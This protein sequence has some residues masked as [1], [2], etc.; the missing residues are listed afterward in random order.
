MWSHG[1]PLTARSNQYELVNGA[2]SQS[3][4]SPFD[5]PYG[6][7]SWRVPKIVY[8]TRKMFLLLIADLVLLGIILHILSPLISL[9]HH[10]QELFPAHFEVTGTQV[11][12]SSI[13]LN[14]QIPRILH[15]TAKNETIPDIWVNSQASCLTTYSQYE[16]K[17]CSSAV[18]PR[19]VLILSFSCGRMTE[20]DPSLQLNIRG[21]Y[22][23]GTIIH[24]LSNAP[25][26]S[27]ILLFTTMVGS[28]LIWI[29]YATKRFLS[30]ESKLIISLII[31][32]S[33]VRYRRE[34]PTILWFRLPNI[35]HLK[36][37]SIFSLYPTASPG[38]GLNC[39]HMLLSC[40]R[41]VL[42]SSLWLLQTI[43]SSSLLCLR[44]QFRLLPLL[45][46][47]HK[48]PIYRQ[49]PGTAGMLTP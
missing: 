29:P 3:S 12:P 17:V 9:L 15:Q 44:R 11:S 2:E 47:A 35:P 1:H 23:Y 43:C 31:A 33:K 26:L 46:S 10:N 41:R 45:G 27:D 20:P 42:Y 39:N 34:S 25:M 36:E 4:V 32:S 14:H 30:T 5:Y 40:H 48:F 49:Q 28:I 13:H 16:Y 18:L 37:Q 19:H 21:S 8:R 7:L 22:K 38:S 6:I 24:S